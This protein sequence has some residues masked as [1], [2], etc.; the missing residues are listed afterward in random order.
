L[1]FL[2]DSDFYCDEPV[3]KF[4]L[5]KE[6]SL[7]A[8]LA[9]ATCGQTGFA[10]EIRFKRVSNTCTSKAGTVLKKIFKSNHNDLL[11]TY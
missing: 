6:Y 1:D 10:A 7:L 8:W 9:T 11:R 5:G 4:G 3:L 2:P